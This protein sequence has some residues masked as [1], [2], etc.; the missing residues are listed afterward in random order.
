MDGMPP[1]NAL[2]AFEAAARHLSLT[3]AAAELNVSPGAVSHQIRGLEALLGVDL[4]ERRVRAIVLTAAGERLYPGLQTGFLHIREAV[5]G[6]Q[7]LDSERVLVVATPPG[8]TAK[9]LAA[10]L[11]RF[12]GANPEIDTRI[13]SS[14]NNANFA[15]DGVDLAIR[16]M[17]DDP[18]PDAALDM[19]KLVS[20]SLV[21]VCSPKLIESS[22]PLDK[23][24]RL[25]H[26]PLIRDD[27][28]LPRARMP[29]WTDW[30]AAAGLPHVEIARGLSFNSAE[31]ALDAASE[32]AGVLLVTD[33]L[34]YDLLH[35]GRLVI[36]VPLTL[37]AGRAYYLVRPRRARERPPVRAFIDWLKQE[38]AALDWSM[39]AP[40]RASRRG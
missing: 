27:T 38:F 31:H 40:A 2:R 16:N 37:P 15:T 5:S 35:A 12:A 10:R 34:A 39:F 13:S 11:Y 14:L 25:A 17:P 21:P 7:Q 20:L 26:A 22:G 4:F 23:P 1:L 28:L 19:E 33:I 30:F 3:K 36:P 6:L 8:L 24:E 32:G 9:W 29:A 18:P